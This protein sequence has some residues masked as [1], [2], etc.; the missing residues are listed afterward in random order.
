[1]KK[2]NHPRVPL[3]W[4][5]AFAVYT[6]GV[7]LKSLFK[8]KIDKEEIK[9]LK[10]PMIVI[11][12][13][14][15]NFDFVITAFSMWP[16]KLNFLVSSYYLNSNLLGFFLKLV[17][18]IPKRQFIPDSP[19]ILSAY[20]AILNNQSIIIF[21]EGQVEYYGATVT[22]DPNIAKLIKRFRVPVVNIKLRGGYLTSSKWNNRNYPAR[23]E[24]TCELLLSKEQLQSM[25]EEEIFE[26]VS[27]GLSY[28]EFSWQRERMIPSKKKRSA[29]GLE[30][31]LFRCPVCKKDF[32]ITAKKNILSCTACGYTVK[33]NKFGFFE[34]VN[35]KEPI[36]ES[37]SDWFRMQQKELRNEIP[38]RLPFITNCNLMSTKRGRLGY[39][40]RG[41][42]VLTLKEDGFLFEGIKDNIPYSN[43]FSVK[44]QS[45][46]THDS[47][48]WGID[49]IGEDCNYAFCPDDPRKTIL[50]VEI[51]QILRDR[52]EGE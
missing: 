45:S 25:S 50:M 41:K 5:Y 7:F 12:N 37:T 14:Q 51:Y 4:L 40:M 2:S 21:P 30:N 32:T 47:G 26:V 20:R 24:V 39:V 49:F 33:L 38:G 9:D 31:I 48:V 34:A 44:T 3:G 27:K 15:S 10:G 19:A 42:G 22:V 46:V 17:G 18:A 6:I 52:L 29:E 35:D 23:R 13:H 36:F 43:L 16:I 1:M 28:D 11:S 8:V